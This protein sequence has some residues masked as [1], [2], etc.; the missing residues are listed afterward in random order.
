MYDH[1]QQTEILLDA[2]RFMAKFRQ[3][4]DN[5][6]IIEDAVTKILNIFMPYIDNARESIDKDQKWISQIYIREKFLID[7]LI[8]GSL[9]DRTPIFK[10][11]LDGPATVYNIIKKNV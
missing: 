9:E 7:V 10:W 3:D 1:L 8:G 4:T 11:W 5:V 6:K 2:L